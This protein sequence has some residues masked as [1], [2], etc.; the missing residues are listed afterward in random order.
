MSKLYGVALITNS[1]I[2]DLIL[3]S[4]LDEES[5]NKNDYVYDGEYDY[6][7]DINNTLNTDISRYTKVYKTLNGAK[8]LRDSFG[9]DS[10]MRLRYAIPAGV[11]WKREYNTPTHQAVI[12]DITKKWDDIIDKR[13]EERTKI[14]NKD[15][16]R[17]K[18]KKSK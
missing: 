13:I 4:V 11:G 12:I 15:I 14:F 9:T 1:K 10:V 18:S 6:I 7:I 8:R 5:F 16:E 17:L 2:R 3:S